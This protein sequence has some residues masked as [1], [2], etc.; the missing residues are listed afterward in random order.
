MSASFRYIAGSHLFAAEFF[1]KLSGEIEK[2]KPSRTENARYHEI[3]RN[4]MSYVMGAIMSSVAFLEATINELFST[5]AESAF[6]VGLSDENTIRLASV[7]K[8]EHIRQRTSILEKYQLALELSGMPL[9]DKGLQPF[10]D[11]KLLIQVRNALVHYVSDPVFTGPLSDGGILQELEQKLGGKFAL[12]PFAMTLSIGHGLAGEPIT[13]SI[14]RPVFFPDLCLGHGCASWAVD[15]S[16]KFVDE[17][18]S[19][20]GWPPP[21]E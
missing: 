6:G 8:L 21:Y 7:W 2:E 1:S 11:T 17:F 5:A 20:L 18:C 15:I 4:H 13:M 14:E 3:T 19:R 10:Q 9:L 16:R 12:S